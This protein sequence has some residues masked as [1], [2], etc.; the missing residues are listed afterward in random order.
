[1]REM[2]QGV[3]PGGVRRLVSGVGSFGASVVRGLVALAVLAVIAVAAVVGLGAFAFREGVSTLSQIAEIGGRKDSATENKIAERDPEARVAA[4][5]L[6]SD[7][8][9]N[10]VAADQKF[11]GKTI[12]VT[13]QVDDI[14]KDLMNSMYVTLTGDGVFGHVQCYFAQA[15]EAQ[16]AG[17][18]KG[19]TVSIKGRCDGKM[20]NVLMRGCTLEK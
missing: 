7:Y 8:E 10:E 11:K 1:M 6:F 3:G 9:E 20:M 16:L 17:L 15:H 4:R 13:G 5:V 2:Q 12:L 14:K 19:M 18:R